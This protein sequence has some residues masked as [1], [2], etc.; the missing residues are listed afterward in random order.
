MDGTSVS[1][2][3]RL[4]TF[5]PGA[6]TNLGKAKSHSIWVM[7]LRD[8]NVGHEVPEFVS[9]AVYHHHHQT[10]GGNQGLQCTI[11]CKNL[12]RGGGTTPSPPPV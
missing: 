4:Y 9:Q 1:L 5:C 11:G 3:C 8:E 10:E 7:V 2:F 12:Q 6:G